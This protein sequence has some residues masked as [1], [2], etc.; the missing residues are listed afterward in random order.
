MIHS[1]KF[2]CL[3]SPV[4]R[5]GLQARCDGESGYSTLRANRSGSARSPRNRGIGQRRSCHRRCFRGRAAAN[6]HGLNIVLIHQRTGAVDHFAEECQFVIGEAS[7]KRDQQ[8][9][10]RCQQGG[11]R[12]AFE[13]GRRRLPD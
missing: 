1:S 4:A 9:F 7:R 12:H 10:A 3:G 11:S 13:F 6:G 8:R 5:R 2:L